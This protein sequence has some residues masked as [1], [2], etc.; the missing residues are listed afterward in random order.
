MFEKF[1]ASDVD[2]AGRGGEYTVQA[3]FGWTNGVA[4][5]AASN[6]GNILTAPTC[7]PLLGGGVRESNSAIWMRP[8][9][10]GLGAVVNTLILSV[11]VGMIL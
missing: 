5:W 8:V 3:G 9:G 7:P 10:K 4:L 11:V 6:Y 2:S 1:S